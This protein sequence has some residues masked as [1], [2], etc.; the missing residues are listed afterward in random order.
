VAKPVAYE[1]FL[2]VHDEAFDAWLG[3]L[4]VDYGVIS[5][6]ARPNHPILRV[7]AS[8]E[9]AFASIV[10]RL[11]SIDWISGATATDM[12]A[13]ASDFA[14]L[15]LPIA[16]IERGEPTPHLE[17][18]G[19]P[20]VW[21]TGQFNQVTQ[22]FEQHQWPG[23]YRI[24][25]RVNFWCLKRYTE[26]WVRE[27]LM[28]QFGHIGAG[29]SEVFLPITHLD[30]FGTILQ[31]LHFDASSDLSTL[32]GDDSQRFVRWEAS[33]TLNAVFYRAPLVIP[34][35]YAAAGGGVDYIDQ[36]VPASEDLTVQDEGDD[37]LDQQ[38][39]DF[40]SAI[41]S[42]SHNLYRPYTLPSN[43]SQ[44]P[45]AG[46]ATV[47]ISRVTPDGRRDF[48]A[49]RV[50]ANAP[51]DQVDVTNRPVQPDVD[52]VVLLSV[53]FQYL[54][55]AL[56]GLDVYSNP[57]THVHPAPPVWRSALQDA[58][59]ARPKW[60]KVHRFTLVT[61]PIMD[62]SIRGRGVLALARFAR[63]NVRHL[64]SGTKVLP[65][66]TT[67]VG[68]DTQYDWTG[69]TLRQP[70]LLVV[71]LTPTGASDTLTAEDDVTTPVFTKTEALND[72]VH[73]GA[74]ILLQPQADSLRLL[75]PTTLTVAQ[76]YAQGY[77][78]VFAGH[79]L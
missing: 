20:K 48:G 33:F 19:V 12:R 72:A 44:W 2:R 18:S 62:V 57:G 74:V 67:P 52:S 35:S 17:H 4:T 66:T 51:A 42:Q 27:F 14:V 47:E 63:I 32:E 15:P 53:S 55:D 43:V 30:P 13:N 25:Y 29:E 5:G 54:S 22:E 76:V 21:R 60:T 10:E 68:P 75:V 73:Q 56:I 6:T 78:G 79:E 40:S 1:N 26:A 8:P 37:P 3:Q 58:L 39:A 46:A 41:T 50:T 24:E 77:H 7:M 28:A 23:M 49:L 31:A 45:K 34:A 36:V 70:Y 16:T 9:R 59:P 71:A 61:Q 64:R 11:V 38:G 65:T 69:L